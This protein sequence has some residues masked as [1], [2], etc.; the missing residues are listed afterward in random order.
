VCNFYDQ[1][2]K[3][4]Y[5]LYWMLTCFLIACQPHSG[6]REL[7]F[8]FERAILEEGLP[9][10]IVPC[11][12]VST[13]D[14]LL[15]KSSDSDSSIVGI[16][17]CVSLYG[18]HFFTKGEKYNLQVTQDNIDDSLKN[19]ILTNQYKGKNY[20]TFLITHITKAE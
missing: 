20:S 17:Q 7:H 18:R 13:A 3:G 1:Q 14:A 10:L 19:W 8:T 5:F 2:M 11:G 15:F 4:K 9:E 12:T 16:V 6:T